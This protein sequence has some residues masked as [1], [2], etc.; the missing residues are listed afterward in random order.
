MGLSHGSRVFCAAHVHSKVESKGVISSLLLPPR[1]PGF[2]Q[3]VFTKY[4]DLSCGMCK[5]DKIGAKIKTFREDENVL[6]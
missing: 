6:H 2:M 4:I 5:K 1:R 3:N